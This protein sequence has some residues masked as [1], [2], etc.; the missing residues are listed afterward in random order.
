MREQR[1]QPTFP[2]MWRG[3]IAILGGCLVGLGLVAAPALAATDRLDYADQANPICKSANQQALDLYEA[4]EAEIERLES[5]RPKNRKQAR[6]RRARAD[7]L[8]E[9]EPFQ[10]QAIYQAELNQLKALSAP[11]GYENTVATWLGARQEFSTLYLQIIQL[12]QREEQGFGS[13]PRHPSR[14]ALKRRHKRYQA[15]ERR[16]DAAID[17]ILIIA[18]VDLELG[19][20]MGASYCVTGATG[21]LPAFVADP[22]D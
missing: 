17:R 11:P 18:A 14:K 6:R 8:Y 2:S 20:R 19:T 16:Y 1:V 9:Q 12:E 15:L 7:Q 3:G 10:A 22:G 13:F 21:R 4:T 5:L